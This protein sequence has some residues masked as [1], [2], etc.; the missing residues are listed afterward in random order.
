MKSLLLTPLDYCKN[1]LPFRNLPQFDAPSLPPPQIN[2]NAKKH[3]DEL[4][5][6][7]PEDFFQ[8]DVELSDP[9]ASA[10]EADL[11][12]QLGRGNSRRKRKVGRESVYKRWD[13]R[14]P[15]SFEFADSIPSETRKRIKEALDLWERNTCLRFLE[16]G[17]DVDRLEF[18]DGGGCSSFVGRTGGTQVSQN[19]KFLKKREKTHKFI[20]IFSLQ[21][22]A[23]AGA[24]CQI[25]F[26]RRKRIFLLNFFCIQ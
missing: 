9:Q 13:S 6:N 24:V 22:A 26:F 11:L 19:C 23:S 17:P 3:L 10:I 4:S 12:Q 8:G 5:V 1:L 25:N 14:R 21:T 15:I 7:D 18:Y 2:K 16:N 20:F